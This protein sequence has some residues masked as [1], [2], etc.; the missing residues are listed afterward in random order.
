VPKWGLSAS[1][2]AKSCPP[3]KLFLLFFAPPIGVSLQR[4]AKLFKARTA[5]S[6]QW[7]ALRVEAISHP[8]IQYLTVRHGIH[9]TGIF[10]SIHSLYWVVY[11]GCRRF[12]FGFQPPWPIGK[13]FKISE[14]PTQ[15]GTMWHLQETYL[16]RTWF[17][18]APW[19]P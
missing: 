7:P 1:A 6:C 17:F 4:R 11:D 12:I 5:L 10:L 16:Q 3:R 19:T 18:M 8:A 2:K 15:S 13:Y 14:D 9:G